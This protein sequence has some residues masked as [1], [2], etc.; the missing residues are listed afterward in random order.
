MRKRIVLS[1]VALILGIIV[2]LLYSNNVVIENNTISAFIRN[3]I[4]DFLWTISFY[5]LCINLSKKITQKY[6]LV[7]S[8]YALALGVII[9]LMQL[10]NIINGTF[11]V[12]DIATY[13]VAILFAC[14]V[15]IFI[16]G[17]KNEKK[18]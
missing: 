2:Y 7:T 1:I 15:E 12:F 16:W 3:Y 4:P 8:L 9:E 13:L 11:D 5:F 10:L 6:F 18:C 17:D 14:F